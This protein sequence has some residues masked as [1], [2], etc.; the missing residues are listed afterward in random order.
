MKRSQFSDTQKAFII[1]QVADGALRHLGPRRIGHHRLRV[2]RLAA[3]S[4]EKVPEASSSTMATPPRSSAR[5]HRV[6]ESHRRV[7]RYFNNTTED[8]SYAQE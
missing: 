6:R 4:P 1:R 2:G 7:P 8:R 5:A 3:G